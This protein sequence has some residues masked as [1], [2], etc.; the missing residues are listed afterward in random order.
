MA[1]CRER[2]TELSALVNEFILRCAGGAVG[3]GAVGCGVGCIEVGGDDVCLRLGESVGAALAVRTPVSTQRLLP[4]ARRCS[5]TNTLLSEH[6][7]PKARLWGRCVGWWV[8]WLGGGVVAGP[9]KPAGL[10]AYQPRVQ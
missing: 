9:S 5:R 1:L 4:R 3:W 7:P 2:T 6:L 8:G 10:L